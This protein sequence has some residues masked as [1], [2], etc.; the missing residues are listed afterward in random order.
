MMQLTG[1]RTS[2]VVDLVMV[3]IVTVVCIL[4]TKKKMQKSQEF[5]IKDSGRPGGYD[6][7]FVVLT[8]RTTG[9]LYPTSGVPIRGFSL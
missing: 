3:T 8:P 5:I 1:K 6:T 9:T 4:D 7:G 2:L